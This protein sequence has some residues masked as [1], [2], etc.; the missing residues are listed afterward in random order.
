[1]RRVAVTLAVIVWA[2]PARA[3]TAP[4]QGDPSRGVE[5]LPRTLFHMTAERLSGDDPRLVWDTHFGGELDLVDYGLGRFTFVGDYEA[6]LGEELRTFDPNQG[7]YILAGSA[8]ARARGTE[9]AAV[10]H[11]QS[12]HLSDRAKEEPVDWNMVGGRV[13]RRFLVGKAALDARADLR[14]VIKKSFVDYSWELDAAVRTGVNVS[15]HTDVIASGGVRYLGVDGSR[16]RDNQI[17]YRIEGGVRF[18]GRAGAIELFV[19]A[20]RRID[21]FPLETGT[22]QWA[23]A[24]FRL[25]SRE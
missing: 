8:S 15:E 9:F 19:A 3:Q 23:S 2:L 24:G 13:L 1:M 16:N 21:P 14:G 22:A 18:K 20:E 6:I 5:F 10:F 7:T 17:G 11:H 12:R 4:A 25:L